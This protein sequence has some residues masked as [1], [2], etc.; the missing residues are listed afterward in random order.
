MRS[1]VWTLIHYNCYPYEKRNLWQ[2]DR[3]G[4]SNENTRSQPSTP[5]EEASEETSPADTF[6]LLV[7]PDC[8]NKSLLFK[9]PSLWSYV[10]AALQTNILYL[11]LSLPVEEGD[12]LDSVPFS[13]SKNE[14]KSF[15]HYVGSVVTGLKVAKS[16]NL[17]CTWCF[18]LHI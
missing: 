5:R 1:L 8:E 15:C 4:R 10:T 7:V 12:T 11:H 13:F 16:L 2:T 18:F 9:L 3:K 14:S 6:I 17:Q